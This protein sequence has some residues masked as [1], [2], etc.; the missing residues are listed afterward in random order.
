MVSTPTTYP[1]DLESLLLT[2]PD[3]NPSDIALIEKAYHRAEQAHEGQTRKSGEPYFIH[4]VAVASILADLKLD[5]EAIAAGLP[6]LTSP[7]P[8]LKRVIDHYK[9]GLSC[10]PSDPKAIASH[11]QKMFA[12]DSYQN[13]KSTVEKARLDLNWEIEEQ[14]LINIYQAVLSDDSKDSL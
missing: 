2:V 5:A 12:P 14:K 9:I 10:D 8:E 4:C 1:K 13:L 3:M 6:I 7:N 11:I